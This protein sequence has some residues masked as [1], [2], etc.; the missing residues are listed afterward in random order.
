MLWF[1]VVDSSNRIL[2]VLE[3]RIVDETYALA[4]SGFV[5]EHLDAT[6]SAKGRKYLV[7]R[8][9]CRVRGEV[10][11]IET[12]RWPDISCGHC[13]GVVVV[14][15]DVLHWL[16]SGWVDVGHRLVHGCGCTRHGCADH[17]RAGSW[18]KCCRVGLVPIGRGPSTLRFA[19]FVLFG[20]SVTD[21]RSVCSVR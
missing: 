19:S 11:H 15:I 12:S 17:S 10:F 8:Q 13:L 1:G 18:R 4:F 3:V 7:Q 9:F 5:I 2:R 14:W 21:L 6:D 16:A 20:V